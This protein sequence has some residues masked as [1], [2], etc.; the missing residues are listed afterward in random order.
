MLRMVTK[1]SCTLK[2]SIF[3]ALNH[4]N[5]T[6]LAKVTKIFTVIVINVIIIKKK[7]TKLRKL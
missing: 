4:A 6:R 5:F 3:T 1:L 7:R 2:K